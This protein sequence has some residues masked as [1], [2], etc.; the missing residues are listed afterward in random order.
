MGAAT[1]VL[2]YKTEQIF[3]NILIFWVLCAL[4]KKC[5]EPTRKLKCNK[6]KLRSGQYAGK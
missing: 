6:E 2:I 3:K 5:I 1:T 4:E